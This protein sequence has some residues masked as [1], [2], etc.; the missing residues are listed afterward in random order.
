MYTADLV[1]FV[2]ECQVNFHLYVDDL[3]T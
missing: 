2:G 1:D 3:Q